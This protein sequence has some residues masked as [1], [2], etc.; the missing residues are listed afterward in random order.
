MMCSLLSPSFGSAVRPP[1]R[2]GPADPAAAPPRERPRLHR[3]EEWGR[4]LGRLC[5]TR[6]SSC[7]VR[8]VAPSGRLSESA[9]PSLRCTRLQIKSASASRLRSVTSIVDALHPH[10]ENRRSQMC[11]GQR[12][13]A[14][15][16]EEQA[17]HIQAQRALPPSLPPLLP[18]CHAS[19]LSH[20]LT[21]SPSCPPL[22]LSPSSC[23]LSRRKPVEDGKILAASAALIL[24]PAP[25][26]TPVDEYERPPPSAER[27]R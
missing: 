2:P 18:P 21:L 8:R 16:R 19:F 13:G 23:H 27:G 1:H 24:C 25:T 22:F 9:L 5:E 15:G 14:S 26:E 12:R 4:R 11:L 7:E 17:R 10:P 6:Y 3:K 20:S